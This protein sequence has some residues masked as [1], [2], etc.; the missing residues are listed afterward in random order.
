VKRLVFIRPD[1]ESDL[2][3]A[4][5]WYEDQRPG[6]GGEFLKRFGHAISVLEERAERHPLYYRDFRQLLLRRFPYKVFYRIEGARVIV[7]RVL[8]A[9]RDHPRHLGG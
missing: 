5:R 3:E 2:L 9:K 6:L 7:F 1:A 4:K 8:H